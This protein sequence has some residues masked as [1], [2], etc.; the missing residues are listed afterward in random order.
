MPTARSLVDAEAH[1]AIDRGASLP[2]CGRPARALRRRRFVPDSEGRGGEESGAWLDVGGADAPRD[3][4]G[5]QNRRPPLSAG[6]RSEAPTHLG[7]ARALCFAAD[8]RR[9]SAL[10]K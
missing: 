7:R 3:A 1:P 6:A 10:R 2:Y 9:H 8:F 5:A 4:A